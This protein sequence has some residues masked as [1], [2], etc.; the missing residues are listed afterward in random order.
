MPV[1]YP[2]PDFLSPEIQYRG[3]MPWK[4]VALSIDPGKTIKDQWGGNVMI[5]YEK[6]AMIE[7]ANVITEFG[8]D[9]LNIGFGLGLIDSAI[10]SFREERGIK[11]RDIKKHTIIEVHPQIHDIMRTD[12][13]YNKPDVEVIEADWFDVIDDL[14]QYDAVFF[15]T[16]FDVNYELF[17]KKAPGLIKPGGILSFYNDFDNHQWG[18]F[19]QNAVSSYGR[20]FECTF[21]PGHIVSYFDFEADPPEYLIPRILFS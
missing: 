13:W 20:P 8:G 12:G 18:S 6:P 1:P 7:S 21:V 4:D 14:P 3:T 9:I 17:F 19:V 16:Y 5:E 2:L 11:K 15:D 10:E